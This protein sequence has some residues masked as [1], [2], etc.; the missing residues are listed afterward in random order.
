MML[1]S[2]YVMGKCFILYYA[3]KHN[4]KKTNIIKYLLIRELLVFIALSVRDKGSR[5]KRGYF[6]IFGGIVMPIVLICTMLTLN[7]SK[8]LMNGET[9]TDVQS[10]YHINDNKITKVTMNGHMVRFKG[11]NE[12][13]KGD[14]ISIKAKNVE[15]DNHQLIKPTV[16]DEQS[17]KYKKIDE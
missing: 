14:R 6:L 17:F 15:I 3:L 13:K 5:D 7:N 8:E 12:L 11:D 10:V 1:E 4:I 9:T 16:K 2:Q